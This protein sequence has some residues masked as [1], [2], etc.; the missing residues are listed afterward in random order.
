M[1]VDSKETGALKILFETARKGEVNK[2][3][4]KEHFEGLTSK[5]PAT[6]SQRECEC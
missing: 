5:T 3:L 1:L 2:G 6:I 4:S